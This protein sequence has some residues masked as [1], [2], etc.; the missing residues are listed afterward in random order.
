MAACSAQGRH[1]L[2]R[3]ALANVPVGVE[4]AFQGDDFHLEALF[5]EKIEGFLGGVRSGGGG[6]EVDDDSGGVAAEQADLG[7]GEGGS[8]GG[9]DVGD[10]GEIGGDAVHL[11][12][13]EQG[14]VV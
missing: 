12:F 1:V 4:A 8:A 2:L 13:D 11:A 7:L 5:G 14:E 9:E 3:P 6:V 10:S